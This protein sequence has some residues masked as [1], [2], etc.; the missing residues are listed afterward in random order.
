MYMHTQH[1]HTNLDACNAP[2]NHGRHHAECEL[3]DHIVVKVVLNAHH[4]PRPARLAERVCVCVHVYVCVCACVHV[5][6]RV[7]IKE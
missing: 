3:V 1:T 6:M 7:C 5:R 2:I 4:W